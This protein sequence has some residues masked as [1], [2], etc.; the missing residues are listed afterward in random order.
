MLQF[1]KKR[2]KRRKIAIIFL[3]IRSVLTCVL[4]AQK[5][6]PIVI[7]FEY[8]QHMFWLRNKK[9]IFLVT[10]SYLGALRSHVLVLYG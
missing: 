7:I 3:S 9:I 6:R 10:H 4:D 2:K 5:N 8:L 1:R